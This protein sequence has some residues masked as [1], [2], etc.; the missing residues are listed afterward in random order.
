LSSGRGQP[1][2]E[3]LR[4]LYE[5]AL[6]QKKPMPHH[7]QHQQQDAVTSFDDDEQSVTTASTTTAV[8][9]P[10]WRCCRRG[11][12]GTATL[13]GRRAENADGGRWTSTVGDCESLGS[14]SEVTPTGVYGLS[15]ISTSPPIS[16]QANTVLPD[17]VAVNQNDGDDDEVEHSRQHRCASTTK[18]HYKN[19]AP[20]TTSTTDPSAR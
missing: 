10:W 11:G 7:H 18:V 9:G 3:E 5:A 1:Y 17:V 2:A 6:R 12:S 14:G 20:T 16:H 4:Q 15:Y 19:D 8:G 13:S